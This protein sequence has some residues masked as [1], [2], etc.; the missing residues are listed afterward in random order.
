LHS[1]REALVHLPSD[2]ASLGEGRRFVARTLRDWNVEES[3]IQPVLLVANELVANAIVHARSA[4]VLSLAESSGGD[5]LLR[6]SDESRALPVPQAPTVDD[7]GGRG[8]ILVEALSDR[9]GID[10]DARGKSVWVAFAGAFA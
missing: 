8:L 7:D 3:R 5:L 1:V 9:W 6:V 2:V 4:P 10:T